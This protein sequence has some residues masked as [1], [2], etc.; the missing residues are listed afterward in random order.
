MILLHNS[1]KISLAMVVLPLPPRAHLQ[2][3]SG[4]SVSGVGQLRLVGQFLLVGQLRPVWQFRLVGQLCLVGQV[5]LDGSSESAAQGIIT[6]ESVLSKTAFFPEM[7][8]G[9]VLVPMNL[10]GVDRPR[11][12]RLGEYQ[13]RTA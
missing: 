2:Q 3:T 10:Q 1:Q 4:S 8:E 6:S 11:G 12:Q 7:R 13:R 9:S 5:L